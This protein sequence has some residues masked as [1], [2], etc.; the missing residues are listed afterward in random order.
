MSR[1]W[2]LRAN[3]NVRAAIRHRLGTARA[4]QAKGRDAILQ[5]GILSVLDHPARMQRAQD[6]LALPDKFRASTL[7]AQTDFP[8]HTGHCVPG[9]HA[10]LSLVLAEWNCPTIRV[11]PACINAQNGELRTPRIKD[12]IT[13]QNKNDRRS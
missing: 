9:G 12:K 4:G 8:D 2:R 10:P 5:S 11:N 3:G 6:M 13:I 7:T 1:T